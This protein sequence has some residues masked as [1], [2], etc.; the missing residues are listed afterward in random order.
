[1]CGCVCGYVCV[2]RRVARSHTHARGTVSQV[3][4]TLPWRTGVKMLLEA[5][6]G[7]LHLHREGIIHRWVARGCRLQHYHALTCCGAE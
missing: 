1:M 5:A 7:V 4:G 2:L 3:R 6:A